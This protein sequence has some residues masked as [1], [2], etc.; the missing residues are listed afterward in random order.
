MKIIDY[1]SC[2]VGGIEEIATPFER[3]SALGTLDFSAPEYRL[4]LKPDSRSDLF[5]IALIG[6]FLLTG[7][8]PP[9]GQAWENASSAHDFLH[10]K[11]RPSSI[12][13]PMVPMWMDNV[14]KKALAIRQEARPESMS[15]F[16]HQLRHP[17]PEFLEKEALPFVERNPLLFW[18]ILA[19]ISLAGWLATWVLLR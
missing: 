9:F 6:Y 19:F 4:G 1:G 11:Y 18:K 14:L 5:S 3:H 7:G 8:K 13:H 16:I 2:R 10:L 17:D 12:H 15:E